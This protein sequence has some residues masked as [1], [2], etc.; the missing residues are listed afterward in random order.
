MRAPICCSLDMNSYEAIVLANEDSCAIPAAAL[1]GVPGVFV[2]EEDRMAQ[3]TAFERNVNSRNRTT[4]ALRSYSRHDTPLRALEV[5][6][7]EQSVFLEDVRMTWRNVRFAR[8][9][10]WNGEGAQQDQQ[11]S[12]EQCNAML[13]CRTTYCWTPLGAFGLMT[14]TNA[15]PDTP[16]RER[17]DPMNNSPSIS[18]ISIGRS[19]VA[20]IVAYE[21]VRRSCAYVVDE[22]IICMPRC[23]LSGSGPGLAPPVATNTNRPW[24][25]GPPVPAS[26][27][28]PRWRT[29]TSVS[30]RRKASRVASCSAALTSPS[31]P[32]NGLTPAPAG[33]P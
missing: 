6:E 33:L 9:K 7:T 21:P 2:R 26:N 29:K 8:C 5:V 16:Y 32:L 13:T 31:C 10:P 12:N 25:P 22:T 3:Q 18:K 24:L 20:R 11:S 14:F 30:A 15:S 1:G 27:Q 19:G 23:A 17:Y 4:V 28:L